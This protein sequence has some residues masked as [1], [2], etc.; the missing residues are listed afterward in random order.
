MI[1]CEGCRVDGKKTVFCKSL[2]EIR[3]CAIS[4]QFMTCG[5]CKNLDNC[6]HLKRNTGTDKEA[7][8]KLKQ[9]N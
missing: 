4:K 1:N 5:D 9:K 7:L 3:N 6:E 8:L 2:C